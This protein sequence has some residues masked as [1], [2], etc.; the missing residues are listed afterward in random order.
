MSNTTTMANSTIAAPCSSRAWVLT[1]VAKLDARGPKVEPPLLYL[2]APTTTLR[3]AAAVD[4]SE[5]ILGRGIL[6]V[7]RSYGPFGHATREAQT[8]NDPKGL[9]TLLAS[10]SYR[11]TDPPEID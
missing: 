1:G 2:M 5:L 7:H 8:E 3:I 10:P 6:S 4:T 9:C 11:S